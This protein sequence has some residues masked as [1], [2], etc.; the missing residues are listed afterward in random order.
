MFKYGGDIDM[1]L[2]E[3]LLRKFKPLF[4]QSVQGDQPNEIVHEI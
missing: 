2:K 4:T 1:G 3:S